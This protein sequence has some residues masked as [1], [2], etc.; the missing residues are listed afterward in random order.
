MRKKSHPTTIELVNHN[1]A[2]I[3]YHKINY[4]KLTQ[5]R[6]TGAQQRKEERG[7]SEKKKN[8]KRGDG[9][10]AAVSVKLVGNACIRWWS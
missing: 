6:L 2:S 1:L 4:R 7:M 9:K 3:S 5:I 10:K 8:V